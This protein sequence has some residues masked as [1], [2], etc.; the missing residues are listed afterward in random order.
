MMKHLPPTTACCLSILRILCA[1]NGEPHGHISS[2]LADVESCINDR[3]DSALA[4][5]STLDFSQIHKQSEIARFTLDKSIAFDKNYIDDGSFVAEMEVAADWY[6]LHGSDEECANAFYYLA[7]QQKDAGSIAEAAVNFSRALDLAECQQDWF[8]SGIATR[9]LS[10]IY[11]SIYNYD[12]SLDY[13]KRS[14]AAFVKAEKP[15]HILYARMKLALAFYNNGS[16]NEC[17]SLCDSLRAEASSIGNNGVLA[18]ALTTL[19]TIYINEK[20]PQVDS[21]LILLDRVAELYPLTPQKQAMY[22]WALFLDGE[23]REAENEM[24]SA[25]QSARNGKDSLAVNSWACKIAKETGD[26]EQYAALQKAI[27]D[28]TDELVRNTVLLS[29]DYA[30]TQYYRQQEVLLSQRIERNKYLAAAVSFFV[31]LLVAVLLF[32]ARLRNERLAEKCHANEVLAEKLSL[33]GSTVEETLDF[34]FDVLNKLSDAYYHPNTAKQDIFKSILS[35]YVSDISSRERLS[36]SIE[37]N[38]NIIHDDV[39][40]NLRAEIPTLKEKDIKLFSLYIFGFSY[41]AISVF[42]PEFSSVNSAYSRVSR[43]RKTISESGAEHTDFF[44]SFLN[45]HS[46]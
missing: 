23:R 17:R 25:Y 5:L 33:Y 10:D 46:E 16:I 21:T 41:K 35:E 28:K 22:A 39:I 37:Q 38:I 7:D 34:S 26:L 2:I 12:L 24:K 36:S 15:A 13:A 19:A 20:P 18:D 14:V 42:F 9:N 11:L 40:T 31:I 3:P 29:V 8:L 32:I 45:R 1:C 27:V 4:V 30:Q 6:S 44:L 43:L